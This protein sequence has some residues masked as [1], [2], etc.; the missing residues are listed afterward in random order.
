MK[1]TCIGA[2]SLPRVKNR[3]IVHFSQRMILPRSVLFSSV[4][5]TL[6]TVPQQPMTEYTTPIH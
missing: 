3:D 1:W 4:W 6:H 5:N 2:R